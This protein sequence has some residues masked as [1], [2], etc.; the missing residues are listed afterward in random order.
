MANGN[1]DEGGG[2]PPKNPK[3]GK[4]RPIIARTEDVGQHQLDPDLTDEALGKIKEENA[5]FAERLKLMQQTQ[6]EQTRLFKSR[7]TGSQREEYELALKVLET[8]KKE[9][10]DLEDKALKQMEL[11]DAIEDKNSAEWKAHDDE[12]KRYEKKARKR[13]EDASDEEKQAHRVIGALDNVADANKDVE[14]SARE[15]TKGLLGVGDGAQKFMDVVS[16]P[17]KLQAFGTGVLQALNPLNLFMAALTKVIQSTIMVAGEIDEARASFMKSTGATRSMTVAIEQQAY[18]MRTTGVDAK[19]LF[20]AHEALVRGM[21]DFTKASPAQQASLRETTAYMQELGISSQMT[22][23][24]ANEATKSLGYG[25]DEVEGVMLEVAG[26]A[27]GLNLPFDAVAKDFASVSK[28]LA[29]YGKDV[30]GVFKDLSRQAKST[31]LSVDGLLGVVEQFDTFE[32]AGKA[33]GKLNAIM[34]GPYLNSIDMLNASEADRIEILKSSMKQAGMNFKDMG[35]YEQKNVASS[36]GVGVDEAR[37]LFGAETEQTKLEA[38]KKSQV[39]DRARAAQSIREEMLLAMK[40]MAVNITEYLPNILEAIRTVTDWLESIMGWFN[41]QSTGTKLGVVAG[42]GAAAWGASALAKKGISKLLQSRGAQAMTGGRAGQMR[43]WRGQTMKGKWQTLKRMGGRGV[44]G[45]QLPSGQMTATKGD[46]KILQK[47]AKKAQP[48]RISR[49]LQAIKDFKFPKVKMPKWMTKVPDVLKGIGD[50][51]RG[52]STKPGIKRLFMGAIEAIANFFKGFGRAGGVIARFL[53]PLELAY[54]TV[55]SFID[56]FHMF[57]EAANDADGIIERIT[58]TIFAFW[59]SI[60]D[61]AARA[62][63]SLVNFGVWLANLLLPEKWH[64][65]ELDLAGRIRDSLDNMDFGFIGETFEHMGTAILA[66]LGKMLPDRIAGWLGIDY[67]AAR[68]EEELF[69]MQA[70]ENRRAK[71]EGREA[72]TLTAADVDD[73]VFQSGGTSGKNVV[74]PIDKDD[75]IMGAKR[76]GA[77]DAMIERMN[78]MGPLQ[79]LGKALSE[80]TSTAGRTTT[81]TQQAKQ[82]V[83]INV[84]IGQKK[85]ETIVLDSLDSPAGARRLGAFA[86]H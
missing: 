46:T 45:P 43:G 58:G 74:T 26:V 55:R 36:L 18:A 35:K 60:G 40:S 3:A 70:A 48:G 82:P 24:I 11:R 77:I 22:A 8:N 41:D 12:M 47:M 65:P 39:K 6:I 31:G 76:G 86:Q 61:G 53:Y 73:F 62:T 37:K 1:N 7:L 79:H 21:V 5:L 71:R 25:F 17:K 81:S 14:D 10:K 69:T 32:G 83:V 30:M 66:S 67:E 34:G 56:N 42:G 28:K 9:I 27:A 16:D 57:G 38:L 50:I 20:Q 63:D 2:G 51:L 4:D 33:V 75:V 84:H 13:K 44:S 29:F 15:A 80:A 68:K 49:G 52:T 54:H 19:E 23:D 59:I 85:I 72:K 64:L 78:N